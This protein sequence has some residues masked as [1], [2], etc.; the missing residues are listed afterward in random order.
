[1]NRELSM[2]ELENIS[3]G[4]VRLNTTRMRIGFTELNQG[5][6]L[7]NCTDDEAI[8]LVAQMY[9]IYKHEGDVALETATLTAFKNNGWI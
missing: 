2:E 5:Y 7:K 6:D 3:G 9:A 1:M 4:T 8:A